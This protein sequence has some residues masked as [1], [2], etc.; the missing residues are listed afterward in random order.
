MPLSS[1]TLKIIEQKLLKEMWKKQNIEGQHSR[2]PLG[3]IIFTY[4]SD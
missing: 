2:D 1:P 3:D 4:V